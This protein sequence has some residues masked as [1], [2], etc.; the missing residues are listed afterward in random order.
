MPRRW[1]TTA[2]AGHGR[3]GTDA[4]VQAAIG[5][6]RAELDASAADLTRAGVL[7]LH[8][9]AGADSAQLLTSSAPDPAGQLVQREAVG[10]LDDAIEELPERLRFVVRGYFFDGRPMA[11]LAAELGVTESRISQLRA[12]AR[13]TVAGRA[14][15]TVARHIRTRRADIRAPDRRGLPG[16]HRRSRRP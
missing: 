2:A 7:S 10:Y 11:E 3:A 6:S 4:E 8:T 14:A 9:P 12:E 5:F 13:P 16:L 15:R 1:P